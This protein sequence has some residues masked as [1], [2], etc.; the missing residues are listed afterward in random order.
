MKKYNVFMM[1]AA[2][3]LLQIAAKNAG[4]TK[5]YSAVDTSVIPDA[6][7]VLDEKGDSMDSDTGRASV[8]VEPAEIVPP[9]RPIV[10][11]TPA[12]KPKPAVRKQAPVASAPVARQA[13]AAPA[14]ALAPKQ[15]T[16]IN[17]DKVPA[18][19][20]APLM[21]RL[22]L[23]EQLIERHHR[24]YDYRA[25]TVKQLQEILKALDEPFEKAFQ[26]AKPSEANVP[27]PAVPTQISTPAPA[28]PAE[29][30]SEMPSAS[31]PPEPPVPTMEKP[32]SPPK[33]NKA[34]SPAPEMPTP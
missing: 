9:P 26:E 29:P 34:G 30:A 31:T 15:E 10:K 24:A 4:P 14:P 13:E 23:V 19:E 28:P 27:V 18:S 3:A 25:F 7:I 22:K 5:S 2:S 20:T 8:P 33:E 11:S 32:E 12:P 16:R 21:Q 17:Y 6:G 1:V